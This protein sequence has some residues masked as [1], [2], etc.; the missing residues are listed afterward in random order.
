MRMAWALLY[1]INHTILLSFSLS[2]ILLLKNNINGQAYDSFE[3]LFSILLGS[4]GLLA[5]L[6]SPISP[7]LPLLYECHRIGKRATY[8]HALLSIVCATI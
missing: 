4:I 5:H 6:A 8:T 7:P 3:Y 1:H 2:L